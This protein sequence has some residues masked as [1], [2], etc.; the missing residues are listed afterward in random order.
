MS[1]TD[2]PVLAAGISAYTQLSAP[3]S[4]LHRR[5]HAP[6]L[7]EALC[8]RGLVESRKE[9]QLTTAS[10]SSTR[11]FDPRE[12][13]LIMQRAGLEPLVPFPGV[14]R[15]WPSVHLN[16]GQEIAPFLSNVRRRGTACRQCAAWK[17]GAARRAQLTAAA[18]ETM[19]AAGFEPLVAYPGASRPWRARHVHCGREV[20][21]TLNLVRRSGGGC[22]SCSLAARGWR[23]WSEAEATSFVLAIGL[24][25]LEPYPGSVSKPWRVRH[26]TCG[27]DVSPRLGNLAQGQG[28]C[29][30]CGQEATHRAL[31]LADEDAGLLMRRAGLQPQSPFPGVDS[32]WPCRHQPCGEVV[33]PTYSNIKRGQG[34]CLR[35]A[36]RAASLRLRMPDEQAIAVFTSAGLTPL[37]GYPG[38]SKP[39][40]A[41]HLCGREVSPTLSNVRTG[42]GICRYCNSAFPYAGE[43]DLYLVTDGFALKIGIAAPGSVRIATH[44]RWGWQHLWSVRVATG[45]LAYNLEQSVIAWW[46][47]DLG[48]PAAYPASAMPQEGATETAEAAAVESAATLKWVLRRL[49]E[50]GYGSPR[51]RMADESAVSEAKEI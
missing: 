34:G 33:S 29:R 3:G 45:D 49:E 23:T 7:R 39:W 6:A 44:R 30:L 50:V 19:L 24:D 15:P 8:R 48:L 28:A 9:V 4:A 16:C 27:R 13:A 46:R 11:R 10:A 14:H 38:S 20:S 21:P 35:C 1:A 42:R 5:V 37:E 47:D 2:R 12:A 22:R 32:P 41:R 17:R 40:V 36:A 31:K 25:P 18:T 43:A 26:R 51:L